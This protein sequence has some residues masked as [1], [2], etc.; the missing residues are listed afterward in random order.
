M[1]LATQPEDF[2]INEECTIVTPTG[3]LKPELVVINQGPD[4]VIDVT[5]RHGSLGYLEESY[6]S[7]VK[8]YTPLLPHLVHQLKCEPGVVLPIVIGTRGAMPQTT[9]E[10]LADLNITDHS[11]FKNL[12][13]LALRNSLDIYHGFMDYDAPR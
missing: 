1:K 10:C 9:I 8:K 12:A 11:T 7:K 5:V 13:L 3:T 4:L 6:R 2:K